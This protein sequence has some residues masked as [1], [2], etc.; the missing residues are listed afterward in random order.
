M[1]LPISINS[2]V[3]ATRR[4][5]FLARADADRMARRARDAG[6]QPRSLLLARVAAAV[7][8]RRRT[9]R[10]DNAPVHG[11]SRSS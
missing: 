8:G 5:D 10:I 2:A 3:A 4:Q 9:G 11:L 1:D 7:L 6:H